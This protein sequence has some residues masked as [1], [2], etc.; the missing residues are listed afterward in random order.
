MGVVHVDNNNFKTEVLESS[1]PVL[2]DFFADWCGP[3]KMVGPI[4][5]ELAGEYDGKFKVCKLNIDDAQDIAAEFGVMSIPTLI[6]F[7]D[8]QKVDQAVGALPKGGI[9]EY[10]KKYI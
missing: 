7:K 9:E 4:V 8:G 10:M 1:M 6:F 2:V 3:C 5:E